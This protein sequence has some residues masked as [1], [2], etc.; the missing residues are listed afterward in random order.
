MQVL[1]GPQDR[2]I[3]RIREAF[4]SATKT[5]DIAV[6][7]IS[8]KRVVNTILK[9]HAKGTTIRVVIDQRL[10]RTKYSK[11]KYLVKHGV[12]LRTVRVRRGLM[13][14]KFILIDRKWLIAGSA[15]LSNDAN[16]RNHEFVLFS[17][18]RPIVR[19]FSAK[20]EELWQLGK[21]S[22]IKKKGGRGDNKI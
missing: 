11:H 1:F 21:Q 5:I 3:N 13:H 14:D 7:L 9:A 8:S 17:R 22:P 6:F 10:A 16:Y 12:E 18:Y 19:Q 2:V 15:N 20:F 4:V